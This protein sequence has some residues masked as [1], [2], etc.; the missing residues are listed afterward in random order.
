MNTGKF[1]SDI[2]SLPLAL[3]DIYHHDEPSERLRLALPAA[4]IQE[5]RTR[6][7]IPS[8]WVGKLNA[9]D[10][11]AVRYM[12]QEHL[13]LNSH[14][15][16]QSIFAF[17]LPIQACDIDSYYGNRNIRNKYN[18]VRY[19]GWARNADGVTV[20]DVAE[21]IAK[22]RLGDSRRSPYR[23][24]FAGISWDVREGAVS[25]LYKLAKGADMQGRTGCRNVRVEPAHH[26]VY[27]FYQIIV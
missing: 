2:S 5:N 27:A 19:N 22:H 12:M 21:Q 15:T 16:A 7:D 24:P 9:G 26:A 20:S 6:L 10:A 8:G 11:D 14:I 25:D 1:R 18:G 13:R 4:L 23:L 3:L 17:N